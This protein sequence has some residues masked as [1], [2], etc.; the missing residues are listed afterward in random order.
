[1]GGSESSL[2]PNYGYRVLNIMPN[3]PISNTNIRRMVDFICYEPKTQEDP[4][5]SEILQYHNDKNLKLT[6]NIYNFITREKRE[7]TFYP[8]NE[9][10]GD[11][12]LG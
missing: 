2:Y 8:N 1:M 6:L 10:G 12:L 11:S 9:W 4:T 7:V 5:L 3:S